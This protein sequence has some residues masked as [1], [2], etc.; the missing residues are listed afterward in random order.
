MKDDF[1]LELFFYK[2]IG[3]KLYFFVRIVFEVE[4]KELVKV[5]LIVEKYLFLDFVYLERIGLF[6][7]KVFDDEMELFGEDLYFYFLIVVINFNVE[8]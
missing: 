1:L 8:V 2:F 7:L 5:M 6:F 4:C 3:N